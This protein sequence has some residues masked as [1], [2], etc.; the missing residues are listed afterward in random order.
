MKKKYMRQ[1]IGCTE[2]DICCDGGVIFNKINSTKTNKIWIN[3]HCSDY[4][5]NNDVQ[6]LFE[7]P[8]YFIPFNFNE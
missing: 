6:M 1:I 8:F 5:F 2:T 3:T 7:H 4:Y